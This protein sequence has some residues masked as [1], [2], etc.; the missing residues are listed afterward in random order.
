VDSRPGPVQDRVRAMMNDW[1]GALE[2][3]IVMAQDEGHLRKDVD[4]A[5]LAFELN[6]LFFGANF[7]FYLRLDADAVGKARRAVD[8]RLAALRV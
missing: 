2:R 5:Q 1:I 6:S 8:A 4:P 3:A 7:A